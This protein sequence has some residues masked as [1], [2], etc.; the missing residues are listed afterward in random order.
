MGVVPERKVVEAHIEK[1]ME[2]GDKIVFRGESNQEPG[3]P[4][5]DIVIVFSE[6]EH[7]RFK[8]Q[9][10]DL[11]MEMEIELVEALCGFTRTV[12][13]LDGRKIDITSPPGEVLGHGNIK[14][15]KHQG[16]PFRRDPFA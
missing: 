13:H 8:R 14:L 5:G 1:G 16:M 15:V 4:A 3:V 7:P 12:T 10:Q 9:N 6:K 11:V 2:D